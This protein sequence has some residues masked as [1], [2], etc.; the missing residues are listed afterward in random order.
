MDTL[1]D[2]FASKAT[3]ACPGVFDALSALLAQQAGFKALF[4]SGSALSY[5]SLGRPDIGLIT[6]SELVD[7]AARIADRVSIPILV[8]ADG[9]M[10]GV[11]DVARLVRQ[12]DR[13]GAAAVQIEDQAEVKPAN[14][15][16]SRPLIPVEAMLGKIKAAQ[17]AR[18]R[19]E[20][21]IS[22]RTDAA[23]SVDFSEAMRRAEAYVQA[24]CDLLFIEGVRTER[25]LTQIGERFGGQIPL[26]HN[27]FLGGPSP[28]DNIEA[29]GQFGFSIGLFSGAS[30]STMIR[31]ATEMLTE[32][33]RTGGL[34]G[35]AD[36]MH[37]NA[38][39]IDMIGAAPF[40]ASFSQS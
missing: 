4:L 6:A 31:A 40:L 30:I 29:L 1:K 3:I 11:A 32:L 15:L 24:G 14:A 20:F 10:G 34:S 8:D 38:T 23:V 21:L 18:L 19:D 36:K 39:M 5:S 2:I 33:N 17:D 25:E 22:A 13:A 28:V 12:L 27:M 35:V 9:G 37:N 26:V 16:T 7:A